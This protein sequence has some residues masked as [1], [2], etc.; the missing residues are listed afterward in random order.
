MVLSARPPLTRPSPSGRG[1]RSSFKRYS[2]EPIRN[3]QSAIRNAL[4]RA[5]FRPPEVEQGRAVRRIVLIRPDQ[6][7]DLLFATP[8]LGRL[9]EAFPA[10]QIAGLVGPWGRAVWAR[11]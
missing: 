11:Q 10:A 4:L 3:P 2:L 6:V 8:A 9:R 5:L 1:F 7:G